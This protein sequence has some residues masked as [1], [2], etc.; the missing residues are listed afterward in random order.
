MSISIE[1][2]YFLEGMVSMLDITADIAIGAYIGRIDVDKILY[3]VYQQQQSLQSSIST[4]SRQYT[5]CAAGQIKDAVL[6]WRSN[7][8]TLLQLQ[9]CSISSLTSS[10]DQMNELFLS[11]AGGIANEFM[12]QRGIISKDITGQPIKPMG[13]KIDFADVQ[14]MR[15]ARAVEAYLDADPTIAYYLVNL[16]E[17]HTRIEQDIRNLDYP[18]FCANF[19]SAINQGNRR[20]E[21]STR[22]S[23]NNEHHRERLDNK[24]N[25]IKQQKRLTR[26]AVKRS[27]RSLNQLVAPGAY[28]AFS[29]QAG[30]TIN[31][32]LFDYHVVKTYDIIDHTE[33]PNTVHIP[34]K[35]SIKSKQGD[36]L[37]Q[38]CVVF[39][40]TPV[41]DQ[42]ISLSLH[43]RDKESEI[44]LIQKTNWSGYT[45]QGRSCIEFTQL[46]DL[47]PAGSDILSFFAGNT[48]RIYYKN[49]KAVIR[50]IKR[51]VHQH[52]IDITGIPSNV[53]KYMCKP[54]MAFDE[55]VDYDT[56][57]AK[58][59]RD[60]LPLFN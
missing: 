3:T 42:I 10:E 22:N 6:S 52:L 32:Q 23:L 33:N 11:V 9:T 56:G 55:L 2:Q 15:S 14:V 50:A 27:A 54:T 59:Q 25:K 58:L 48:N 57:L 31:G 40:N 53:Y 18:V 51:N 60:V 17:Q 37:A 8:A 34:Y 24:S 44:E 28:Q 7:K 5:E 47:P 30:F 38:G 12:N 13:M 29:S 41:L 46:I 45:Q 39:H 26:K 36:H 49:R 43:V 19:T 20:V 16:K 21:Q 35:L 4:S 1:S